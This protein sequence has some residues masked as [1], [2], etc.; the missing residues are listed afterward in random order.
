MHA[1]VPLNL[2]AHGQR[3]QL[4]ICKMSLAQT[5]LQQTGMVDHRVV[6]HAAIAAYLLVQGGPTISGGAGGG[7][8]GLVQHL[9][10]GARPKP[11]LVGRDHLRL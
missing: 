2:Y 4:R 8:G 10:G 7:G 5:T 1:E 3:E 9:P 11:L 6:Q